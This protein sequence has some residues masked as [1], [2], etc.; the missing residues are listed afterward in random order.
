[1]MA[2][3]NPTQHPRGKGGKFVKKGVGVTTLPLGGRVKHR[4]QRVKAS[5]NPY[6][7]KV[8]PVN[9]SNSPP[10]QL[11]SKR[12][13]PRGKPIEQMSF[14]FLA[15]K[16]RRARARAEERARRRQTPRKRS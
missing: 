8:G 12:T 10:S 2:K 9:I 6:S 1:M 11:L 5:V 4:P 14:K 15:D 16:K 7:G 3:F 13:K